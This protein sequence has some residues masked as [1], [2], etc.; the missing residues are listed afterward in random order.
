MTIRPERPDEFPVIRSLIEE[1]FRAAPVSDGDEH[2][3]AERRRAES[4]Y[5]PCLALVAAEGDRL[6][7][8]V[9]F[10]RHSLGDG[11]QVLLLAP[12]AVRADMRNQGIGAALV[13]EGLRRGAEAGFGSVVLLGD[14]AYY[15][16]FGFRPCSD[17]GIRNTD[18]IPDAYV[19]ALELRQGA[20]CGKHTTISFNG[21]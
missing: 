2:R 15:G 4:V 17:C 9:M 6:A 7:G 18:G 14:S 21:L 8:H 20:L 10:T 1:V 12:L 5:L 16:R 13:R 11:T 19:L 3:F